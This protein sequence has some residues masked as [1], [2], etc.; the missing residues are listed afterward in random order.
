NQY[1][2]L[3]T[4]DETGSPWSTP[5]YFAH[6]DFTEFYWIS[7]PDARHSRNIAGR[8][9]V[10]ISIFDSQAKI[11]TGQGVYM[12]GLASV[13]EET[14]AGRAVV[15]LRSLAHGGRAWTSDDVGP[16]APRRLYRAVADAHWILAKDGRPDH[17]IPVPHVS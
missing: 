16:D 12:S 17:R 5:V 2:V 13:V 6:S 10:G 11:G 3:A 14:D 15:S 9:G 4:A 7:S 8:P 1:M